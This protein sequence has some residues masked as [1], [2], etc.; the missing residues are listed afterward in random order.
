MENENE[1]NNINKSQRK[2]GLQNLTNNEKKS[3]VIK[4][5]SSY[6]S[7]ILSPYFIRRWSLK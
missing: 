2:G 3:L 1:N 7:S 4:D 6:C 5:F